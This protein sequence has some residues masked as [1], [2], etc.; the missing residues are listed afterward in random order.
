MGVSIFGNTVTMIIMAI[1]LVLVV[2]GI[3]SVIVMKKKHIAE[4]KRT[5]VVFVTMCLGMFLVGI[6]MYTFMIWLASVTMAS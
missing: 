3:I 4:Q 6:F 1:L 5:I 2:A